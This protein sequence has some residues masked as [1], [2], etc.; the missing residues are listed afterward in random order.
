[1]A[2]L[3]LNVRI[4]CNAYRGL[5]VLLHLLLA[6]SLDGGGWLSSRLGRLTF[7]EILSVRI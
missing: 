5:E 2:L 4:L 6:L 1:M 3:F 7:E